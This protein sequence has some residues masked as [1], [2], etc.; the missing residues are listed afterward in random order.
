MRETD[1]IRVFDSQG[2][3]YK[4]AFQ[5]F[6]DHTDQKRNAKQW[7]YQ[8]VEGLPARNVFIDAGAGNGEIT[9]AVAP[10]FARTIAIEPNAYLLRDL[11]HA[12]PGVEA[13]GEPILVAN[14]RARADLVLY[15]APDWP[16]ALRLQ[17]PPERVWF[18]G[19]QVARNSAEAR[20]RP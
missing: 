13:I 2:A 18:R 4:Q 17:R 15:S 5:V 7:L 14:P 16:E 1:C 12:I 19:R 8:L 10:L 20:L 9:R 3:D 6:L 11:Q